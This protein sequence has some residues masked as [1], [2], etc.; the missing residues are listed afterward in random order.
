MDIQTVAFSLS[1][2]GFPWV[3]F[4]ET[5]TSPCLLPVP[6]KYE[7]E[8]FIILAFSVFGWLHSTMC[9]WRGPLSFLGRIL[10]QTWLSAAKRCSESV[11][12]VVPVGFFHS[13]CH[14]RETGHQVYYSRVG[15]CDWSSLRHFL[16]PLKLA[17]C[18][19]LQLPAEMLDMLLWCIRFSYCWPH[20]E[21]YRSALRD[22]YLHG[23]PGDYLSL[24]QSPANFLTCRARILLGQWVSFGFQA[25]CKIHQTFS[26]LHSFSAA[27]ISYTVHFSQ[28]LDVWNLVKAED[29]VKCEWTA[30]V[31][32]GSL[33]LFPRCCTVDLLCVGFTVFFFCFVLFLRE[34]WHLL[35][36][37][38][39]YLNCKLYRVHNCSPFSVGN[40]YKIVF[41]DHFFLF[42]VFF[43]VFFFPLT[44]ENQI[45]Q[46]QSL[47]SSLGIVCFYFL[48]P[49]IKRNL[50]TVN[51]YYCAEI[52]MSL[53]KCIWMS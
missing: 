40:P 39:D 8:C 49:M 46:L 1:P 37:C 17:G 35:Q 29:G 2:H 44:V 13:Q 19:A 27:I 41:S 20:A 5:T 52:W 15:C 22:L 16:L 25:S 53:Q 32:L 11:S 34:R 45:V 31:S 9:P 36:Y 51:K 42:L 3:P 14:W 28:T 23:L 33:A 4:P 43:F 21:W 6:G 47:S 10:E 50:K 7:V 24:S 30:S 18:P 48:E 26:C 12:R 38:D